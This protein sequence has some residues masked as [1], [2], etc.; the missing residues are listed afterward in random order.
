LRKVGQPGR[1]LKGHAHRENALEDPVVEIPGDAIPIVQD[2]Q[3]PHLVMQSGVLDG[4]ASGQSQRLGGRYVFVPE[5]ISSLLVRQIE[6]AVDGASG[7]HRYTHERLHGWVVGREAVAVGMAG[8]FIEP[9]WGRVGDHQAQHA[10]PG[11]P[12][13]NCFLLLLA[14]SDGQELIERGPL[15]VEHPERSVAGPD[16]A[17]GLFD[18]VAEQDREVDIG[19]EHQ[20]GVHQPA[21]FVGVLDPAVGHVPSD[22]YLP[23]LSTPHRGPISGQCPGRGC[24][25]NG[26]MTIRVFL[27]DDHELVR[28]GIR[29]LLVSDDEIEV[30]GEAA[31]AEEALT[32]I[33][34][35]KPDVAIL[36][37]RLE[38]GNGIEVCRDIRSVMP[39][40]ACLMLTSFADDEALYASV[41][42]GAAGY[43]LKQIKARDLIEDV[44]KV[45]AGASLMDPRAVARVVERIANPPKSD[46]ELANLSPQERR[47]LDLIA[48]GKTNAAIAEE[49]FLSTKTVKNYITNLL[50]KLRVTN[51]TEA[52][53]YA[54]KLAGGT[55]NSDRQ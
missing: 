23:P 19:F 30:V 47:I 16:Q 39:D 18:Q 17:A 20:D 40:L 2:R 29:S 14:Q 43:V 15:S 41:M 53:I 10:S 3:H 48:Q 21:E 49:M 55:T 27:L 34:L 8:Q 37:V 24:W 5:I 52:A 42:A 54:N 35:A 33:P 12:S 45:A 9:Q 22:T 31:T 6:V 32:R 44:K 1:A 7:S 28:E 4:D 11:R 36:D 25:H 26:G 46:P 50:A 51:R 13:A 38:D